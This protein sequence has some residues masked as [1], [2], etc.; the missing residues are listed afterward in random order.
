MTMLTNIQPTTGSNLKR[1]AAVWSWRFKRLINH[2]V[3][4]AIAYRERQAALYALRGLDD[5]E[6]KDIGLYRGDLDQTLQ[7]AAR[8]G[9]QRYP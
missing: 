7:R 8:F 2:W 3:A 6:L 9:S 1:N 5:R 4:A